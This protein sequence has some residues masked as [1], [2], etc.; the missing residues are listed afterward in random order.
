M[1]WV[2]AGT[3]G[4]RARLALRASPSASTLMKFSD[5]AALFRA[6]N[7]VW[8]VSLRPGHGQAVLMLESVLFRSLLAGPPGARQNP[9]Q[10]RTSA[11]SPPPTNL[12]RPRLRAPSRRR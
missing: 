2:S 7:T 5:V 1:A 4:A 10:P 8:I 12:P 11:T 6:G 3:V 9:P